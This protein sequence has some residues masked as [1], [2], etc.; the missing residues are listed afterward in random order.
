[1]KTLS[2]AMKIE[3]IVSEI[4]VPV[5][6]GIA[7]PEKVNNTNVHTKLHLYIFMTCFFSEIIFCFFC[8]SGLLMTTQQL[9]NERKGQQSFSDG[10]TPIHAYTQTHTHRDR[11]RGIARRAFAVCTAAWGTLSGT[12]ERAFSMRRNVRPPTSLWLAL[13]LPERN[14]KTPPKPKILGHPASSLHTLLQFRASILRPLCGSTPPPPPQYARI[15]RYNKRM[16]SRYPACLIPRL[17]WT[18]IYTL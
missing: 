5:L 1:M 8:A 18:E 17:P 9:N 10:H 13:A 16:T 11:P 2:V 6:K 4:K 3:L 7:C 12:K 14:P 15:R